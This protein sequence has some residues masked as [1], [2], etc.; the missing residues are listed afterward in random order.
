MDNIKRDLEKIGFSK[1]EA[2][3]YLALLQLGSGTAGQVAKMTSV[4]RT[5]TY[6]VLRDLMAKGLATGVMRQEECV[7]IVEAPERLSSLLHL[8]YQEV[9]QRRRLADQLIMRLQVFHN[10]GAHKPVIRYIESVN[11][12]RSMQREY[13]NLEEDVLQIVGMD[14]LR[15]LY[16]PVD[17]PEHGETISRSGRRIRTIVVSAKPVSYPDE[18]NIEVVRIPPDLLDVKGEMTVCGDRLLLFSYTSGMIAVEIC[19]KTIADTARATL[20][21]SWRWAKEWEGKQNALN[22]E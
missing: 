14:T 19:S 17:Q 7:Y 20:E 18:W 12:L 13:E 2:D 10:V 8:Q 22:Q 5:T 11:G 9:K 15:Q 1:N 4:K 21:M 3:V 6:N 16:D